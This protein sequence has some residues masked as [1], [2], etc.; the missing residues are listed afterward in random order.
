MDESICVIDGFGPLP[1]VRPQS[2]SA[3]GE[4]V[5]QAAAER[6]ALYPI[7]GQTML[8]LGMTPVKN[9]QAVDVRGLTEI[10]DFPARD[11]TITVQAGITMA[12]LQEVV[13]TEK[14]RLP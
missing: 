12:R 9:G 6:A 11:M 10:I 14:L 1:I 5:R 7:G 13:A 2:V 8:N 3:L 4:V